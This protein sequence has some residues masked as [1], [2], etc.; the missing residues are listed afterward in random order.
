MKIIVLS[1]NA[2]ALFNKKLLRQL[3][4]SGELILKKRYSAPI[5][6]Y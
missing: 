2:D 3:N 1:P 6:S 5:R 4:D